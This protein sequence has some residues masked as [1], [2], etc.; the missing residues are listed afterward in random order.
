[1]Y[2][3]NV[4]GPLQQ[5]FESTAVGRTL[6]S[7]CLLVTLITLLTANLPASRLQGLLLSA[8][9][10]YLYAAA[11]DQAWGVF[12]PDPRR[13]TIHVTASVTYADGSQA[14][15]QVPTRDPVIGEY[16]DYRWLKW[17]EY[18]ISPAYSDLWRP[19]ALYVA[20][21]LSTPTRRPTKVTLINRWYDLPPPGQAQNQ[22]LVSTQTFYTTRITE[23]MLRG[24]SG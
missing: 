20:R 9:H 13:Q 17:A 21:T 15:W 12:A 24:K 11:L 1:V 6:I 4:R 16:T 3:A 10:E 23:A 2:K 18:L 5:R 19:A 7:A 8:D 22:P 14:T